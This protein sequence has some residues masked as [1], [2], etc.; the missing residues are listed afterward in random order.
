MEGVDVRKREETQMVRLM[1]GLGQL[2]NGELQGMK[3]QLRPE[4]DNGEK[5]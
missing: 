1:A 4:W 3:L 2:G 5:L